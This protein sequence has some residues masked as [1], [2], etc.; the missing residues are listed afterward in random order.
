MG[1]KFKSKDKKG[2]IFPRECLINFYLVGDR[3][4]KIKKFYSYIDKTP[5][6]W[7]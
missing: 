2:W 1:I 6:K 7:E 3:N 4:G 5:I